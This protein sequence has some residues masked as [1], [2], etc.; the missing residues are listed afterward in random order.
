MV[1]CVRWP[2][3]HTVVSYPSGDLF[4]C[5]RIPSQDHERQLSP[6]TAGMADLRSTFGGVYRDHAPPTLI[7]PLFT[8]STGVNVKQHASGKH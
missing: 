6:C 4:P 1:Q 7:W 3:V 5:V 8:C 2:D